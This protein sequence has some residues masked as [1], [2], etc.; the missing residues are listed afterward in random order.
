M[1]SKI[2]GLVAFGLL[3]LP[4][5][6]NAVQFSW[7]AYEPGVWTYTLTYDPYDNYSVSQA[8][9]TITLSGL[10]GVTAA[11]GPSSTDFIQTELNDTNLLWTPQVSGDGTSVV[12]THVGPGTGNFDVSKHVFGFQIF[13]D[14]IMTALV[15]LVTDGFA[16][17]IQEPANIF[18]GRDLDIATVAY[19]PAPLETVPEPGSLAL[20]GLGLAGLGL[21]RRRKAH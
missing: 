4:L 8:T 11:T 17:D 10:Y 21:S 20:L 7:A 15:P 13:S 2:S 19:G 3:A 9:T 18:D 12:W 14:A 16:R 6:V 1:R 5:T